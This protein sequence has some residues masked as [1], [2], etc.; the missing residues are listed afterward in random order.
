MQILYYK[1]FSIKKSNRFIFMNLANLKI[2]WIIPD[3]NVR[4]VVT[5]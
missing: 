4:A 3:W 5:G 1:Y 2:R